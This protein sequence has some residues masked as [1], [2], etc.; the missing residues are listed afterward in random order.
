MVMRQKRK[1]ISR[2]TGVRAK[3]AK[4]G[5]G[6]FQ[7]KSMRYPFTTRKRIVRAKRRRTVTRGS[8]QGEFQAAIKLRTGKP[9]KI[10]HQKLTALSM[11]KRTLRFQGINPMGRAAAGTTPGFYQL[12]NELVGATETETPVHLFCLNAS[13]NSSSVSVYTMYRLFIQPGGTLD[14]KQTAGQTNT[15]ATTL[16][17]WQAEYRSDTNSVLAGSRRFIS[18]QWY[19]I[20]FL[21]YG[22]RAQPTVYEISLIKLK[23]QWL[24]PLEAPSNSQEASDRQTLWQG[25]AQT[26]MVNPILP[27]MG[28]GVIKSKYKVLKKVT[29]TLQPSLTTE[30]DTSPTSRVVKMFVPD[31]KVYDYCYHADPLIVDDDLNTTK[32]PVQGTAVADYSELPKPRQRLWLMIRCMDTTN[33]NVLTDANTPSYDVCI[34]KKEAMVP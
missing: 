29:F 28:A 11:F 10:N 25:L 7:R 14:F 16:V 23:N 31:G 2:T 13:P 18:P 32:Y 17:D 30:V 26:M 21:C 22:A 33:G 12:K 8:A 34:R 20:R 24:D 27:V 15:G 5:S 1:R 4:T 19:D 6:A 9:R 3:R